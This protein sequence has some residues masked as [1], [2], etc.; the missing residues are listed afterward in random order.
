MYSEM[1]YV[2]SVS[3]S[4]YLV[5]RADETASCMLYIPRRLTEVEVDYLL[6]TDGLP[7]FD[8][9]DDDSNVS[10]N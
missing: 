10:L 3:L 1:L 9:D 5:V 6:M 2:S 4:Q 8:S 7:W